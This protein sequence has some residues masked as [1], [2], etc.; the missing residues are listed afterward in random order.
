[1]SGKK[2]DMAKVLAILAQPKEELP[3]LENVERMKLEVS[4]I[5]KEN[6]VDTRMV[7]IVMPQGVKQPMPLIY[8]P[9]Y[10]M[11]E[12]SLELRDYLAQG[13]AMA[14][15]ADFKDAYNGTIMDD[16]LVFN[17]AA[18]YTL[19]HR[20]EFDKN[21]IALVGGSAGAYMTLMLNGLQL[22]HCV[23]IANGPIA[24]TYFNVACYF[25]KAAELNNQAMM[26][27]M[28]EKAANEEAQ[29]EKPEEEKADK[30]KADKETDKNP[31]LELMQKLQKLPLPFLAG[32]IGIFKP[33]GN[34][35]PAQDEWGKWEAISGVGLADRFSSPI[36]VNHC[37]SDVLVPVDQITKK[38]TYD[39]P[40]DSLPKSFD[41]KIPENLPGKLGCSLEECLPEK[42]TR[43]ECIPVPEDASADIDVP[44]DSSKKFNI[45]IYDDGPAEGYGTHSARMD[46][47][48]RRDVPYLKEMFEKTA[49]QNCVLT[50]AMLK[51]FLI[52]WQGED[53]TLPAHTG[54]DDH[55]YGSLEI[56]RKEVREELS[57]WVAAHGEEA[58]KAVAEEALKSEKDKKVLEVAM[59]EIMKKL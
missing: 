17:N 16:D 41:M 10:E 6:T 46:V 34:N 57:D 43:T 40:G 24:N 13:W 7:S 48:R 19:R 27:M 3:P 53:V 37:T 38:F 45:N 15:P 11:G 42:D 32:L 52:R 21:R 47:G 26:K 14:C 8:V 9:H 54:V 5:T 2:M 31:A 4:Y 58:L 51:S 23:S 59:D 1:M 49:A 28:A 36:L 44:Y 56:Y 33:V 25:E 30:E 29:G 20:P 35:Y 18:L 39:I 12:D 55:V 22:G 50:P